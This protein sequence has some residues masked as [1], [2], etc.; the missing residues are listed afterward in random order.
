MSTPSPIYPG[1]LASRRCS[2]C[3]YA[4]A[5]QP[6]WRLTEVPIDVT[7]CPECGTVN[8]VA[9]EVPH[10]RTAG[11]RHRVRAVLLTLWRLALII[12]TAGALAGLAQAT[13]FSMCVPV[14]VA[15]VGHLGIGPWDPVEV[16]TWRE[17]E[18]S[19]VLGSSGLGAS[20]DWGATTNFVGLLPIICVAMLLWIPTFGGTRWWARGSIAGVALGATTFLFLH[21]ASTTWWL[22]PGTAYPQYLAEQTVGPWVFWMS[23]G[24][25]LGIV[26]PFCW[27]ACALSWV[28]RVGLGEQPGRS[29]TPTETRSAPDVP[30]S[31]RSALP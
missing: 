1:L 27:L 18:R 7:R 12:G 31:V 14:T 5:G 8:P 17:M 21:L 30:H 15:G 2:S 19:G 6:V 29:G 26:L 13:G 3:G 11:V 23:L 10:L 4:L 16:E 24:V 28:K 9:H 22:A 20:V 25:C